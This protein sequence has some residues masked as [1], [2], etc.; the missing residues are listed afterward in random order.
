MQ[1]RGAKG[2]GHASREMLKTIT[3]SVPLLH[4]S[5]YTVVDVRFE[6]GPNSAMET[7]SS[8]FEDSNSF[9][10]ELEEEEDVLQTPNSSPPQDGQNNKRK[11]SIPKK[12]SVDEDEN[13]LNKNRDEMVVVKTEDV[14]Y[15]L[16]TYEDI[17]ETGDQDKS[18]GW[19]ESELEQIDRNRMES[20]RMNCQKRDDCSIC[21]DKANGLHYGVYSCEGYVSRKLIQKILQQYVQVQKL[22]QEVRNND[23]EK[24]FRVQQRLQL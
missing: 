19:N 3:S 1:T 8:Q 15:S 6:T 23:P 11:R 20:A 17:A 18:A 24:A 13:P 10:N 5:S 7:M 22:L 21:G 9:Q 2:G 14:D 12:F 4:D 16:Q